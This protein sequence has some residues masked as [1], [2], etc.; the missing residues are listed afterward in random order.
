M[1]KK[2]FREEYKPVYTD[3]RRGSGKNMGTEGKVGK[4]RVHSTD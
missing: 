3:L 2:R 1:K 4:K